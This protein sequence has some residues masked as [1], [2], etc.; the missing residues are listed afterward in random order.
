MLMIFEVYVCIKVFGARSDHVAEVENQLTLITFRFARFFIFHL[1]TKAYLHCA[2]VTTRS[3]TAL[4]AHSFNYI[5]V[6]NI[7]SG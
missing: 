2:V 3:R 5:C 6:Q 4:C 1:C 7:L